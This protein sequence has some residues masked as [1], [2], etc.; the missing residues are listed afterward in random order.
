MSAGVEVG[1]LRDSTQVFQY[2][3]FICSFAVHTFE[4]RDSSGGV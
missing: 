2:I 4:V 3:V 1:Q